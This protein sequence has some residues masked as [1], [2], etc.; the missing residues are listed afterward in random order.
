M[1]LDRFIYWSGDVKR[2]TKEEIGAALTKYI[3]GG[4]K[5]YWERDRYFVDLPGVPSNPSPYLDVPCP[6]ETRWFEVWL[7]DDSVDV[8]T[9]EADEFTNALAK[10]FVELCTRYWKGQEEY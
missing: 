2:P 8:L 7:G 6:Y 3:G 9:R 10:G 4:G 5:V 1:A